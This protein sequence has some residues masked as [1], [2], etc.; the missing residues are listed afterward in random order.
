MISVSVGVIKEASNPESN[1]KASTQ[2]M[3]GD[4]AAVAS[5]D[6]LIHHHNA[7]LE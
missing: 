1:F 5:D 4:V 3:N 6:N 7:C 2:L